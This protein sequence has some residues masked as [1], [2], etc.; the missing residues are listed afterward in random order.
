MP[1]LPQFDFVGLSGYFSLLL[2]YIGVLWGV[3]K[4][5]IISKGH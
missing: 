1:D 5:I 2:V 4:A 3:N